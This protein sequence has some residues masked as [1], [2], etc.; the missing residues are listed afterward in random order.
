MPVAYAVSLLL[1]S[2]KTLDAG[3]SSLFHTTYK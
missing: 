2:L 3:E 1:K